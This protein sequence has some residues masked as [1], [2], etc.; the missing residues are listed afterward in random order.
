MTI[1][2]PHHFIAGCV[3]DA[4]PLE[5]ELLVQDDR[6]VGGKEAVLVVDD[7]AIPKKGN[8]SVGVAPQYASS[9]G[10]TVQLPNIGVADACAGECR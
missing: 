8:R 2:Q 1:R 4:A 5:L 10:K 9:L 3:W 6:L 7:T